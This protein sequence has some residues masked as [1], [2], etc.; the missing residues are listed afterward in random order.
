MNGTRR[1]EYII[2]LRNKIRE[3]RQGRSR[4]EEKLKRLEEDLEFYQTSL[5]EEE[6]AAAD[7]EQ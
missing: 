2:H 6:Q 7:G 3:C 5:E 4:Q 1:V